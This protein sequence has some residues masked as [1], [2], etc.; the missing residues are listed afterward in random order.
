MVLIQM[1]NLTFTYANSSQPAIHDI[2]LAVDKGEFVLVTGPTGC[3]KTTFCRCLNGLI[4]HFHA[5]ELKGEVVVDGLNTA[6]HQ[7][8][9]LAQKVGLVFQNP[10]NQLV[11]LNAQRE[12]SFAPENLGL[13]REEI[14]KRVEETLD[15]VGI[16]ELSE[17][18]PYEMSGGEQQQVAIASL[19]TLKPKI[20]VLDEPTSNLDPVS[21]K[22][23]LE[24]LNELNKS[25]GITIILIEHR[26]EMVSKFADRAI[27]LDKGRVVLDGNPREVFSTDLVEKLGIGIPKIAQL[28]KILR[29][30]GL[31][32]DIPLSVEEAKNMLLRLI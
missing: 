29:Q 3:G 19:L 6:D 25:S 24:L 18:A 23:I 15:L 10:E 26:L 30:K 27:I 12:L 8:Y 11:A 5:G 17:K 4:P 22:H 20:L 2:D 21:A 16:R 28:F 32:L 31:D 9:E 13:P 7:V 1:K 14:E